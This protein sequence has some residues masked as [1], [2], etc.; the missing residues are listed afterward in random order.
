MS[1][2]RGTAKAF[3]ACPGDD[4]PG[5]R[6]RTPQRSGERS[7]TR[8]ATTT[9]GRNIGREFFDVG[10]GVISQPHPRKGDERAVY[11]HQD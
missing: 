11:L 10:V 1:P 4:L 5:G 8:T 9:P 7:R 2:D 6:R 3:C